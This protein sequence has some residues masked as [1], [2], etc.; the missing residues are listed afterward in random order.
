VPRAITDLREHLE[1]GGPDARKPALRILEHSI[2]RPPEAPALPVIPDTA[3][4][5][6]KLTDAQLVVLCGSEDGLASR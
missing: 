1:R 3:E 4:G 6:E 5:W 2:G